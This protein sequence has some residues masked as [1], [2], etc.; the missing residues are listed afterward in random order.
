MFKF[1][2]RIRNIV[3]VHTTSQKKPHRR[4]I[5]GIV[6]IMVFIF[7]CFMLRLWHLD[8]VALR[9]D[10]AYAV[11]N[12]TAPPLSEA[13]WTILSR[14]PHPAGA[15]LLYGGWTALVGQTEWAVRLLPVLSSVLAMAVIIRLARDLTGSAVVGWWAGAAWAVNP[16]VLY[17]AQDARTLSTLV[18]FSAFN[19][20]LMRR[21]IHGQR[22]A[23]AAYILSQTLTFYLSYVE[24][25]G[26]VAQAGLVLLNYR[27]RLWWVIS[28]LWLPVGV[29]CLPVGLM[30][31]NFV[32]NSRFETHSSGFDAGVLLGQYLPTLLFGSMPPQLTAPLVYGLIGWMMWRGGHI[33]AYGI[34]GVVM[35]MAAFAMLSAASAGFFLPGYL[36]G[37]VPVLS[38]GIGALAVRRPFGLLLSALILGGMLVGTARYWVIDPPK[39]PDWRGLAS[40]LA[41]RAD[42]GAVFVVGTPDTAAEYYLRLP[43][44]FIPPA[45]PNPTDDFAALL[46]RYHTVFVSGDA[47]AESARLYYLAH[48]QRIDDGQPLGVMQFRRWDAP[49]EEITRPLRIT[50]GDVAQLHGWSLAGSG[51]DGSV[52]LLY[53]EALGQTDTL[54]SVLTHISAGLLDPAAPVIS[55][56]HG[57]R[58]GEL[59]TMQWAIGGLYRDDVRLPADLPTG[60]YTVWVGLYDITT[61]QAVPPAPRLPLGVFYR[62]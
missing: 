26:L 18:A 14:E 1:V 57:I 6:S 23:G 21:A 42:D 33:R 62:P 11:L 29:L 44:Y 27:Q 61:Q 53:W 28:R 37:S 13:W 60:W 47:R 25:F 3:F 2:Q 52:L 32:L 30:L 10:E 4:A 17:H 58:R 39:S 40:N 5:G 59:D 46:T 7:A 38:V 19:L 20:L 43:L 8:A 51:Q 22:G 54:H 24:A 12:W 48:A 36:I 9:G 34:A 45:Q 31:L 15:L 41:A 35:P 50:F 49:P 55:L 56:D 16:F